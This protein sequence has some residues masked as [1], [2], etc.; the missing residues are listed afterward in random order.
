MES[1]FDFNEKAPSDQ[2]EATYGPPVDFHEQYSDRKRAFIKGA[3]WQHAQLA[4]KLEAKIAET[5]K[6]RQLLRQIL[7]AGGES[8]YRESIIRASDELEKKT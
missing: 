1:Y 7:E 2:F 5:K 8:E 4:P 3:K 6:F